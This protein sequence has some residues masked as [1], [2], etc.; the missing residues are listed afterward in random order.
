[1][2][3][4]L[5]RPQSVAG[6]AS[7]CEADGV[8]VAACAGGCCRLRNHRA[9]ARVDDRERVLVAMVSTPTR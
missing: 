2:A 4:A 3:A 5:D 1:V 6:S 9:G 7:V 8:R